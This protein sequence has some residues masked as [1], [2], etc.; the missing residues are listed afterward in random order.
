MFLWAFQCKQAV[1][2]LQSTLSHRKIQEGQAQMVVVPVS[3][4]VGN[5]PSG[6]MATGNQPQQDVIMP[7]NIQGIRTFFLIYTDCSDDLRCAYKFDASLVK[8]ITARWTSQ[9]S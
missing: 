5:Q 6:A 4:A 3:G 2:W 9:E 7:Y 8:T 1:V